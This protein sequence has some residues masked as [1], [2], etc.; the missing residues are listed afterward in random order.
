LT[1]TQPQTIIFTSTPPANATV[2]GP[3][4][5][6]TA[7]GG[8]SG[9]AVVFTIDSP[10]AGVCSISGAA[11]SFVGNG[12]C[13]I[14]ANQAGNAN[15]ADAPEV[16]Q[17]FSVSPRA[18]QAPAITSPAAATFYFGI[19]SRF[20]INATGSPG[21]LVT[22]SGALPTGVTFTDDMDG[23]ATLAG[24]PTSAGT[25]MVTLTAK[26]GNAPD[27]TQNFTLTVPDLQKVSIVPTRDVTPAGS[28][29]QFTASG[30]YS[31][32]TTHDLTS[33]VTWTS[34]DVTV[35]TISNL[36]GT[37]GLASAVDK[38]STRITATLG[39]R[40]DS[41][42]LRVTNP[43]LVSIAV[44]PPSPTIARGER[45]T[46]TATGAFSDG[47][48][49]DVTHRAAWTSSNTAA[50]TITPHGGVARGRTT[51]TTAIEATFRGISSSTQLTVR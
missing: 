11:V 48:T 10:A 37:Q 40:S 25:F 8:G 21:P 30:L 41:T 43:L 38:G 6:V 22:E 32:A 1:N 45:Q 31:D 44:S 26:N 27:A 24:I 23:T 4:Y 34:S 50:A 15:F 12:T 28:D 33:S 18:G 19:A 16:Q 7:T 36:A 14:D 9:N 35:A 47:T 13:V 39:G 17:T 29:V 20:T 5:T 2:G 46:F 42:S 3:T 51:G 49:G